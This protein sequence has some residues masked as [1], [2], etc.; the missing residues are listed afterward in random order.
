MVNKPDF[1]AG[2]NQEIST[3][4][5]ELKTPEGELHLR[6]FLPSEDEFALLATGI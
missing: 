1:F 4:I 2:D 6:F 3:E 5:Q